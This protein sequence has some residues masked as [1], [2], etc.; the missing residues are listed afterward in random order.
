MPIER[1]SSSNNRDSIAAANQGGLFS[2]FQSVGFVEGERTKE[3]Q[4]NETASF[5]RP[6]AAELKSVHTI[7]FIGQVT[8]QPVVSGDARTVTGDRLSCKSIAESL[9]CKRMRETGGERQR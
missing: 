6:S 5:W 4:L 2:S 1:I 8:H 7:R 3:S 9:L